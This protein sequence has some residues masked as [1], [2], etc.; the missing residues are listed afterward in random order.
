[1]ETW[2]LVVGVANIVTALAAVAAIIVAALLSLKAI[3][4]ARSGNDSERQEFLTSWSYGLMQSALAINAAATNLVTDPK[5]DGRE[6]KRGLEQAGSDLEARLRLLRPLG[7]L[8]EDASPD[9]RDRTRVFAE[10]VAGIAR[11]Y[12]E[13]SAH[14]R[15]VF[16]NTIFDSTD[17][18]TAQLLANLRDK[19]GTPC[20]TED[21][22]PAWPDLDG[23][24]KTAD[25]LRQQLESPQ[26]APTSREAMRLVMP[27][28]RVKLGLWECTPRGLSSH[29][30]TQISVA[31]FSGR[32][33]CD[34][35]EQAVETWL[36]DWPT[37]LGKIDPSANDIMCTPEEVVDELFRDA[38]NALLERVDALVEELPK[39]EPGVSLRRR[40][41][42][43]GD[44]TRTYQDDG[45]EVSSKP[46]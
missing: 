20:S 18:L 28:I 40:A 7:L 3:H 1:M 37:W 39:T 45:L 35:P 30:E 6:H 38:Q 24:A 36:D 32:A 41:T 25:C 23:S 26:W 17:K 22:Y 8:P 11:A 21:G 27:W 34:Y 12:D 44:S 13:M 9:A 15:G 16:V 10:A 31:K 2:Q 4:E 33:L 42:K 43:Q 46:R 19:L 14:G 29:R 5:H